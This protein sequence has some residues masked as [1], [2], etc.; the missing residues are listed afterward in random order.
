MLDTLVVLPS[1]NERE[2]LTN[3]IEAIWENVPTSFVCVVDDSSPDGT[4]LMVKEFIEKLEDSKKA[5]IHLIVRPE[6]DGRGGAVRRGLDW[7]LRESGKDFSYFLEMDCDFSHPPT[8]IPKGIKMLQEYDVV[9][10]SRYPNGEIIGWP[11]S[12]HILS[13]CANL[14]ARVLLSWRVQDYTNGYRFYSAKAAKFVTQFPQKHKGYIYLSETLSHF[15]SHGMK[16]GSFPIR[17]VNRERGNSNTSI[18]E[19][20]SAFTGIFKIAWDYRFKNHKTSLISTK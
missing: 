1:Y 11:L 12:R 8:D 18:K 7:G 6:K 2:N 3:L 9:L 15:L 14:L 10:G 5:R 16:I 20:I 19:V 13:F 17:F 4:H